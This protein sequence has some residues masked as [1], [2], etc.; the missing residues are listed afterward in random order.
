[1]PWLRKCQIIRQPKTYN[2]YTN[3]ILAILEFKT[4]YNHL[5]NSLSDEFSKTYTKILSW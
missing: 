5:G 4:W 3:S 2:N 1:M